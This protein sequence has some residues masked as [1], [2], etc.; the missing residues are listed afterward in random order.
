VVAKVLPTRGDKGIGGIKLVGHKLKILLLYDL[1]CEPDNRPGHERWFMTGDEF[2]DERHVIKALRRNGHLVEPF[3]IHDDLG[4]LLKKI[5]NMRPDCVFNL[6]ESFQSRR[7]HEAGVMSLLKMLG[8]PYTGASAEALNLCK[9]KALSKKVVAF[10]GVTIPKFAV[11]PAPGLHPGRSNAAELPGMN[12]ASVPWPAICKPLDRDSSEGIS[13]A[14]VVRNL[15][16]CKTHINRL[17]KKFASGVI[18]EEFIHGRELYLGILEVPGK[19]GLQVFPPRELYT[20]TGPGFVTWKSKWDEDYRRKH[21]ID[22][23]RAHK[24]DTKTLIRLDEVARGSYAALG[25]SGY[26][27]LDLRLRPDGEPVFIEANPNPSIRRG[28]DYAA[29]ASAAGI[30]YDRLIE[31]IIR[32]AMESAPARRIA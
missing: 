15:K 1:A 20:G 22:S 30:S 28:D 19:R 17:Q 10:H 31:M 21:G 11:I 4:I 32:T 5:K 18:V 24:L 26:A 3:G 12:L 2:R 14:S 8:I 13:R 7:E 6:C 16:T 23:G 9:D 27:R 25:L 29:A